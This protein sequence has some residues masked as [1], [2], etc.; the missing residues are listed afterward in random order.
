M[1]IRKAFRYRLR[2]RPGQEAWLRRIAGCRRWVWNAALAEQQAR[3]ARGESY[4]NYVAMAKWLTAWR[5]AD[6]TAFLR[7]APVH[8]LQNA[9]KDLNRAFQR[10]FGKKG[11][12]PRFQRRVEHDGFRETDV[13]C[14]A[15]DEA[16]A[17]IRLPKLGWL[18]YRAS[19]PLEGIPK[20]VSVTRDALGWHVSIQTEIE[21]TVASTATAIGAGDRGITNF[22][23][24][25]DGRCIAPLNAHRTALSGLRRYQRSCARKVEAQKK[26]LGITGPIP[27]G[28]RLPVSKRLAKARTRLADYSASIACQRADFLHKLSTELADRHAVFCLEDLRVRNMTRSAAGT[29]EEPGS[30]VA[31]KAALN[32]S[33]LDQGWSEFARQLE[34]KLAWR[35]GQLIKVPPA[36]TSQRCSSCGHTEAANRGGERFVCRVCGLTEHADV[37]AAKNILAAGHAVLAGSSGQADVE[38]QA[39]SGRSRKRQPASAEEG[40]ACAV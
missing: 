34:Y 18:R 32:R 21:G 2:T 14:F 16:T 19:R 5:A 17:R 13:A 30:N 9:L 26:A 35:A 7:E 27:K 28:M 40:A 29:S 4:A 24:L 31:R 36:Y 33:I 20:Q 38:T 39:Q 6:A 8:A 23:A 15:V 22:L 3:H 11:G 37:N 25:A 12:Y 1:T 10:F